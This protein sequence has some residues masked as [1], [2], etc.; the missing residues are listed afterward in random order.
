[1]KESRFL[2]LVNLYLD[3]EITEAETNEL[4]REIRSSAGRMEQYRRYCRMQRACMILAEE[5]RKEVASQLHAN[6][7]RFPEERRNWLSTQ[8]WRGTIYGGTAAVAATVI[9]VISMSGPAQSPGDMARDEGNSSS[10]LVQIPVNEFERE[11]APEIRLATLRERW[12][13]L[14]SR[15]AANLQGQLAS[16]PATPGFEQAPIITE[17]SSASILPERGPLEFRYRTDSISGAR[18]LHGQPRVSEGE[19]EFATFEF[20]R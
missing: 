12:S 1:M 17:W 6:V 7:V 9:L 8:W 15:D 19:I 5:S 4:E 3:G 20:A 13:S 18:I 2:E 16:V 11:S 14:T 10:H